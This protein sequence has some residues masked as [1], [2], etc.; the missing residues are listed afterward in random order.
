M[1]HEI[2]IT[3]AGV[4]LAVYHVADGEAWHKYGEEINSEIDRWIG[5]PKFNP[6]AA[7][8]AFDASVLDA[9]QVRP[10]LLSSF[11]LLPI[12]GR[13]PGGSYYPHPTKAVVKRDCDDVILPGIIGKDSFALPEPRKV[14]LMA[15][16]IIADRPGSHVSFMGYLGEGS[17]FLVCVNLG[18][19]MIAGEKHT[20]FLTVHTGLDGSA[21]MEIMISTVR[22]VC[23]NTVRQARIKS[24]TDS[25]SHTRIKRTSGAPEREDAAADVLGRAMAEVEKGKDWLEALSRIKLTDAR[26]AELVAAVLKAQSKGKLDL[27]K[28]KRAQNKAAEIL[29]LAAGAGRG[30][31]GHETT[32]YGL[33][34]AITEYEQHK[35]TVS[36]ARKADGSVSNADKLLTSK[37]FGGVADRCEIAREVMADLLGDE[38]TETVYE[39]ASVDSVMS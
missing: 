35:A 20:N 15:R 4:A 23:N 39:S 37:N 11:S 38:V 19:M 1:A 12:F 2:T 9:K 6:D 17:R 31:D 33:F 27:K 18:E 29:H 21:S 14:L 32:A 3:E 7:T 8:A 36:G 26:R 28:S 16:K 24:Q 34:Q 22:A 25:G 30:M 10:E 5:T 13:D